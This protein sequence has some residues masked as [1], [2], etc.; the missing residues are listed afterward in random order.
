M[1]REG[2][3]IGPYKLIHRLGNG[4]FGQVWKAEKPGILYPRTAFALKIF[5][6]SGEANI[7]NVIQET[8]IC[9]LASGH[10]NVLRV[11]EAARYEDFLVIVSDYAPN[12]S[13]EDWLE[14]HKGKAPSM[15]EAIRITD[16]I[17]A[18]LEHLHERRII[19]RDI[20]PANVL[21]NGNTPLLADFGLSRIL[22]STVHSKVWAGTPA[23]MAPEAFDRERDEQTDVWAVGVMLYQLVGGHLPFSGTDMHLLSRQ[24]MNIKPQPLSA[25]VPEPLQQVIAKALE[26]EQPRRYQ[27]ASEMREALQLA[28]RQIEDEERYKRELLDTIALLKQEATQLF[29]SKQYPEAVAKWREVLQLDSNLPGIENNIRDAEQLLRNIEERKKRQVPEPETVK[30]DEPKRPPSSSDEP[31]SQVNQK[32]LLFAGVVIILASIIAIS[33]QQIYKKKT[34]TTLNTETNT[35]QALPKDNPSVMSYTETVY[36]VGIDMVGI[37]GGTFTM[38]SLGNDGDPAKNEAQ[39]KIPLPSFYMGKYEVT[40]AQWRAVAKLPK[41]EIDLKPDPSDFEGDN[42]PVEQVSWEEAVEF[43]ERLSIA[44]GK[45]YR[46]PTEAEWEYACRAGSTGEYAGNLKEMAW[47][48]N[49]SGSSPLVADEIY[50][51]DSG[52][53]MKRIRGNGCQTHPVGKKKANGFGLYDM[54]GNVWEWCSNWYFENYNGQDPSAN[55]TGPSTDWGRANRGGSWGSL[56]RDLRSAGRR[57]SRPKHQSSLLGF[58]LVRSYP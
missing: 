34:S 46:L 19:H 33:L 11:H 5:F 27:S 20:K 52:N 42:L 40:Q 53:Y 14:R 31:R 24:V 15:K 16:S 37:E 17:L 50:K 55:P 44:T 36:G 29:N 47:Y 21:M 32:H 48:G 4:A 43:C 25:Q 1:L 35:N 51:T 56:A 45:T 41:A 8:E 6:D 13:L 54:H 10:P 49:N 23:Y 26:T 12:G 22:K 39:Q 3:R 57:G 9:S 18:G 58:R 2:T 30:T 38:G 28:Q 7:D